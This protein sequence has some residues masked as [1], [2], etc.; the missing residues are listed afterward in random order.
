MNLQAKWVGRAIA[1]LSTDEASDLS[2]VD[3]SLKDE[4]GLAR[5]GLADG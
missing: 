2:G 1:W 5:A 4:V 3:F